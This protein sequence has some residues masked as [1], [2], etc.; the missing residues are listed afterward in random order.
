[1]T[2]V[3]LQLIQCNEV[4]RCDFPS[5]FRD[6]SA[7]FAREDV[8]RIDHPFRFHE[9]AARVLRERHEVAFLEVERFRQCARDHHLAAL[10]NAPDPFFG[11]GCFIGHTIRVSDCQNMSRRCTQA[12]W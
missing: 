4:S 3:M 2:Q 9:H 7:F 6:Q 1:M 12:Q 8:V 11:C 10:S 5:R